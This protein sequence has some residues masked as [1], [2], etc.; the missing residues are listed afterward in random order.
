MG[1][2]GDCSGDC[3]GGERACDEPL[4][5]PTSR[6]LCERCATSTVGG[7]ALR[8]PTPASSR[9]RTAAGIRRSRRSAAR[10]S[11]KVRNGRPGPA[12]A[13]GWNRRPKRALLA[14]RASKRCTGSSA[15]SSPCCH[16]GRPRHAPASLARWRR[17]TP[18]RR[19]SAAAS[20]THHASKAWLIRSTWYG[21]VSGRRRGSSSALGPTAPSARSVTPSS[22]AR[23]T[24][25]TGHWKAERWATCG[26]PPRWKSAEDDTPLPGSL[27]SVASNGGRPSRAAQAR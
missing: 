26:Q 16:G 2:W 15:A 5:E 14:L 11:S 7:P 17:G 13:R 3:G 4:T 22:T 27:A 8:A 23:R 25:A 20:Q 1:Q 19:R 6:R 24:S 10:S 12:P 21:L 18:A 9:V